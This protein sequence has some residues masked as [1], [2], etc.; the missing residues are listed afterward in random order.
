MSSRMRRPETVKIDITRGDWLL[1]KKYLTAG[2]QRAMFAG[3]LRSDSN[4]VDGSKVGL[5]RIVEYLL[6]WSITDADD[7]PVVIR[8]QSREAVE[9]ALNALD[10]DSFTEILNAIDAHIEQVEKELS[11]EKN[12]QAIARRSPAIS[13]SR[14]S[15]AGDTKTSSISPLMST[16]SSSKN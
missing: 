2:E 5:S 4:M 13:R 15:S 16:I 11:A 7:R 9:A 14:K 6:D 3:M 1:V 12:G 10:A 8:D